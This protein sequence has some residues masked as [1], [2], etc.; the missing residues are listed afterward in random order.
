MAKGH[1][2]KET[3]RSYLVQSVESA[4]V[5]GWIERIRGSIL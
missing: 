4:Y 1:I 3:P 5:D 2:H